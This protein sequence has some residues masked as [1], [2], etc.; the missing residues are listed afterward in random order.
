MLS[1]CETMSDFVGA[2]EGQGTL[3]AFT[4]LTDQDGREG[5]YVCIHSGQDRTV[6]VTGV[7]GDPR[8]HRRRATS[9]WRIGGGRG[10]TDAVAFEQDREGGRLGERHAYQV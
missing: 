3:P 8:T 6:W 5:P 7:W 2:Q 9:G 10:F 1:V 4:E